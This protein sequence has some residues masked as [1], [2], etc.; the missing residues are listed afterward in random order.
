MI[1]QTVLFQQLDKMPRNLVQASMTH[2]GLLYNMTHF[3][4]KL[5]YLL[6]ILIVILN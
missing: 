4:S 2:L 1:T 6:S 5:I 3:I